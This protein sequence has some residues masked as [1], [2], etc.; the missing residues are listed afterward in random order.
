MDEGVVEGGQ[1]VAD[2]ENVISLL[3]SSNDGGSVVGD[4]FGGFFALLAFFSY[5]TFLLCL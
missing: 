4:L 5:L 3:A 1:N 2:T